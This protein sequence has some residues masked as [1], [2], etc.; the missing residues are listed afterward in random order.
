M[1][2]ELGLELVRLNCFVARAELGDVN[3]SE[4]QALADLVRN[5][6]PPQGAIA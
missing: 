6:L 3:K 1:Q 5:A 4:V 2:H